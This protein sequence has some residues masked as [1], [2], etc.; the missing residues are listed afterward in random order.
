[1]FRPSA[2]IETL[3]RRA[4]LLD[5][6]RRFFD[7]RG[8]LEVE[9]PLLSSGVIVERYIDPPTLSSGGSTRY[10]QASPEAAMKRLVAAGSGPIWQLAHAFREGERGRVHNPEFS[11]LEWYR[12]GFDLHQ[13][14]DEVAELFSILMG[15]VLEI[16]EPC[17]IRYRDLFVEHLGVDPIESSAAELADLA[18]A[19]GVEPPTGFNVGVRD[20]WLDLL[21]SLR[22]QPRLGVA[23]PTFVHDYPAT[24]AALARLNES[25]ERVAERFELFHAGVE[26]SNGYRELLDVTEQ[27][28]RLDETNR[29]RRAD[30]RTELALDERFLAALEAGLPDCSGVAVGFDRVVMLACGATSIDEVIAFTADRV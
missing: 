29:R 8:V 23:R 9:T 20:D 1:M 14:M 18:R 17:K 5:R 11:I 12:P 25:D 15:D 2:S 30:G 21:F 10:L 26:L 16:R 27:R 24:Q 6:T 3:R 19:Q 7:R 28:A 22:I 4:G 13:L